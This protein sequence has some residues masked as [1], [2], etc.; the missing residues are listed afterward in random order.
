M[1]EMWDAGE[2]SRGSLHG[3]RL[4]RAGTGFVIMRWKIQMEQ[5]IRFK[6]VTGRCMVGKMDKWPAA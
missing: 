3:S 1:G 6:T 2:T 5:V 4:A